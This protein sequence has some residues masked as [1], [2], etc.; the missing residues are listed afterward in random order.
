MLGSSSIYS[1]P[2]RLDP[3]CVASRIRWASPPDRLPVARSSVRY[4]MP[5]SARN[6][7]RA[8]IS[9]RICAA[10]FNSVSFNVMDSKKRC[11][12]L[13]EYDVTR[14]IDVSAT[15]TARLSGRSRL[16]P[17]VSHTRLVMKRSIHSRISSD[18]VSR[19]LR[20]RF[21]ITPSN[22]REN[23]NSASERLIL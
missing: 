5:T 21:G 10:I 17:H 6:V 16:P 19:Y 3:I 18:F 7:S 13:I 11:A 1:T 22:L 9:L 23:L 15:R 2:I 14:S 8:R 12:S 4:S 20:S